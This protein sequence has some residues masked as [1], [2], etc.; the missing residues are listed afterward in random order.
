MMFWK[1]KA[2]IPIEQ[3]AMDYVEGISQASDMLERQVVSLSQEESSMPIL[4]RKKEVFAAIWAISAAAIESSKLSVEEKHRISPEILRYLYRRWNTHF[5]TSDEMR[6]FLAERAAAYL[7]N[8]DIHDAQDTGRGA[9]TEFLVAIRAAKE[10]EEWMRPT[11][12]W[13]FATRIEEDISF[14]NGLQ[15]KFRIE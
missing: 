11:L 2:P 13:L 3:L 15:S 12:N 10:V 1:K 14:F 4:G 9:A 7:R 6:D 8:A 5:V